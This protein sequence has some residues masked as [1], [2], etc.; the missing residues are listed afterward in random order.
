[1]VLLLELLCHAHQPF[2]FCVWFLGL[3]DVPTHDPQ[4]TNTTATAAFY[5][6]ILLIND[7]MVDSLSGSRRALSRI[8]IPNKALPA[9]L[10]M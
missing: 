10:D 3:L 1:M 8:D 4:P 7:N 9:Q 2:S 5:F 6:G